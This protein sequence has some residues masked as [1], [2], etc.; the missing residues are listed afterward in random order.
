MLFTAQ[1]QYR[2]ELYQKHLTGYK[3][4]GIAFL[5]R[6]ITI[7]ETCVHNFE[8][9]LKYQSKVW[10]GKNSLRLQKFQQQT[11]KLKNWW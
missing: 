9:E 4:E 1:K 3:K 10:E 2:M 8:L 7:N 6:I 11:S 5:Q